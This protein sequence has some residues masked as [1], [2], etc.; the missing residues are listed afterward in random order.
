MTDISIQWGDDVLAVPLPADWTVQQI[1]TPTII[2]AGNDWPERLAR[3]LTRPEAMRPLGELLSSKPDARIAIIVEDITRHSP[4]TKILEI[5]FRE[6]RHAGIPNENIEIIFATGMHRA[7]TPEEATRKIGTLAEQ[8]TW[9]C[10]PWRDRNAYV[11]LGVV[12]DGGY[13]MEV[14]VDRRVVEADVR[15][16]ISSVSPHLQAGFGG[17]YKMLIPGCSH[18]ETIRRLHLCNIPRRARQQVGQSSNINRMRRLID[19]AGKLLDSQ[20]GVS[21]S[22]QYILDMAGGVATVASG[23]V[24]TC[25]R[26]LAKS[27]SATC[28]VILNAPADVVITS[29]YPRDFDL[30][31]SFKAI[32]N[33]CWAA[34]ENGVIICLTRTP[35]GV[36][37][38]MVSSPIP[39]RRIRQFVRFIGANALSSLIMRLAPSLSSDAIF[40]IRIALQ[41]L[42]R[43]TLVMVSPTL[44]KTDAK[45]PGIYLFDTPQAAIAAAN[46]ELGPGNK[47]VVVFPAGGITYPVLP[48]PACKSSGK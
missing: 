22:V 36:N 6:I 33:T 9:R 44:A 37:M 48:K 2:P 29:A 41:I 31:Q 8:I 1:A 21:F 11:H 10:N 32:A 26:M 42:Q 19:K 12:D 4:L 20:H 35:G 17:G 39:P 28:G 3:A 43:N 16:I 38:P 18:L 23:D 30:W 5:I 25:Q 27:C 7:I 46:A 34:R 13:R 40:F 15:I 45:I 24:I 47:R 14:L